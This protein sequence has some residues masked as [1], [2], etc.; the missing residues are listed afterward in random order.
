MGRRLL[1]CTTG[2]VHTGCS[3]NTGTGLQSRLQVT[4]NGRFRPRQHHSGRRNT[5]IRL[6]FGRGD[7][8]RH[9]RNEKQLG[10]RTNQEGLCVPAQEFS[11]LSYW[12]VLSK[13][14]DP[15]SLSKMIII[16]ITIY[17]LYLFSIL[18]QSHILK[19]TTQCGF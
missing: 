6:V 19:H 9:K 7:S 12:P 2:T 11:T 15:P 16:I 14:F 1:Y 5:G 4:R 17:K 10:P 18:L 8:K 13:H 3:G